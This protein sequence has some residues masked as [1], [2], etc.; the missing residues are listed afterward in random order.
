MVQYILGLGPSVILPVV[1]FLLALLFGQRPG[2]AFRTGLYVGIA[3]V[4]INLA[5]GL[6]MQYMGPAT[7]AMVK[8]T[9][10]HLGI[11]DVGWPAAATLTWGSAIAAFLIPVGLAVNLVLVLLN[12]TRTLDVDIWNYWVFGFSGAMVLAVT[13]SLPLAL[14]AFV[15]TEIV[16]LKIADLTAPMVHEYFGMP[17]IAIPHGN[18]APFALLGIALNWVF[19]RI[20]AFRDWH[21]DADSIRKRFGVLGEPMVIGLVVGAIIS[22]LARMDLKGVLTTSVGLAAAMVILPRMV[23]LLMEGLMPLSESAGEWLKRHAPGRELNIGL[24]AAVLIGDPAVLATGILLIPISIALAVVLPGNHMLPFAD[25]V[26]L[27]FV[28]S[29]TLAAYRGNVLR[30][31]IGGTLISAICLWIGTD[32]APAF[33][34]AAR[35]AS[36]QMPAGA[37]QIVSFLGGTSPITWILTALARWIA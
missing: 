37:T 22:I 19:E 35:L 33:T 20:P 21:L 31:V 26:G 10:L 29:L 3:F 25:L 28:V 11:V 14:V 18:A 1:I 12:L 2:R 4:G 7:Q 8:Q 30:G 32:I 23:A 16:V 13:H 15:L 27:P 9:G 24:D 6:V 5:I 17:G 36:V 34:E